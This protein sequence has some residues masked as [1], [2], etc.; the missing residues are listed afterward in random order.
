[1]KPTHVRLIAIVI[2]LALIAALGISL[3]SSG[4]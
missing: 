3:I 2:V 4:N 1:V